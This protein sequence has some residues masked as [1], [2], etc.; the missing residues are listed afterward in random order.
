M[1]FTVTPWSESA[2]FPLL[3]A[4][5]LIPLAAMV[6]ILY[7]RSSTIDFQKLNFQNPSKI[8]KNRNKTRLKYTHLQSL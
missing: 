7:S 4:L 3:S 5:T 8:H 1:D 2:A 6:A